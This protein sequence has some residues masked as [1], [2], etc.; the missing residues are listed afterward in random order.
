M[1]VCKD[2]YRRKEQKSLRG[3][4]Q[5]IPEINKPRNEQLFDRRGSLIRQCLSDSI[6]G[7]IHSDSFGLQK[8]INSK[9]TGDLWA[10][11]LLY[12]SKDFSR[13][14]GDCK[15]IKML[16][17]NKGSRVKTSVLISPSV[18][19]TSARL[20]ACGSKCQEMS[21]RYTRHVPSHPVY[22]LSLG[23]AARTA[24]GRDTKM[25]TN[26]KTHTRMRPCRG[27]QTHTPLVDSCVMDESHPHTHKH[28]HIYNGV[29]KSDE[30]S[31]LHGKASEITQQQMSHIQ[32]RVVLGAAQPQWGEMP[33]INPY[34]RPSSCPLF[35]SCTWVGIIVCICI[36]HAASFEVSPPPPCFSAC[37]P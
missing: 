4:G 9:F 2:S 23:I 29:N 31:A 20:T 15:T 25:G 12:F 30:S 22:P 8:D 3:S 16:T 36:K 33:Q 21:L 5:S 35:L 19:V 24:Q 17:E 10:G 11:R 7:P 34:K 27:A 18:H 37:S 13:L 6:T 26:T 28:T 32:H 14:A 1:L